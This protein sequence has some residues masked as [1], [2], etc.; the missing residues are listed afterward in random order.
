MLETAI[1]RH[2]PVG[3]D[4]RVCPTHWQLFPR[5]PIRGSWANTSVCPYLPA[6]TFQFSPRYLFYF[7]HS[8]HPTIHDY[9][10]GVGTQDNLCVRVE[11][12]Y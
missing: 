3:A 4:R 7:G 5:F 9:C 12:T 10:R 11:G 8:I 1:V 2:L 6:L